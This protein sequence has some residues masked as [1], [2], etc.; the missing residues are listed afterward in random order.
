M[1]RKFDKIYRIEREDYPIKG[2]Y[3][4]AKAV[5]EKLFD[6]EVEIWEKIDGGNVGIMKEKGKIYLQKKTGHIDNSH[7]QYTYFKDI[8]YYENKH[9]LDKLPDGIGVYFENMRCVHTVK[10]DKLPD[11]LIVI[12]IYDLTTDKFLSHNE[13]EKIC[14]KCGLSLA[15]LLY[16]GPIKKDELIIPELSHYGDY[17]EGIVVKNTKTQVKGKYVKPD[18]VKAVCDSEFWRNKKIEINRLGEQK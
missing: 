13:C 10:Y 7:P 9:K 5:E 18:F 2:K 17:C 11:Y 14:N 3:H 4:L 8:W 1:F 16:K 12:D 15:P 6:G